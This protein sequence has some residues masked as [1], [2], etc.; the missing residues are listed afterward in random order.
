MLEAQTT[1]SAALR[2]RMV[3]CQIRTFDVTDL[4]VVSRFLETPREKFVAPGQDAIAYS[5][6]EVRLPLAG[7]GARSLL[8]PLVA[9]RA[10]QMLEIGPTDRILVVG[11]GSGYIAALVAGL[12]AAAVSLESDAALSAQAKANF[13]E[14]GLN[15]Q[16]VCGPLAAGAPSAGPYDAILIAGAAEAGLET[17][18][19]QLASGGRLLAFHPQAGAA[20]RA[21]LY[22]KVGADIST[23]NVFEGAARLLPEF[24]KKPAFTF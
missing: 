6:F 11:D 21:T 4:G 19:G 9:A 2:R 8:A 3:D 10:M 22:Q 5:D 13:A 14:L 15:A 16:A 7:G 12:A 18:F 17:L 23:R 24:A 1:D 20:S